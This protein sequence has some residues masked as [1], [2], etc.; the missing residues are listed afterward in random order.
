MATKQATI[1]RTW[2]LDRRISAVALI[3]GEFFTTVLSGLNLP[4]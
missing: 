4:R 3:L 2:K 1:S